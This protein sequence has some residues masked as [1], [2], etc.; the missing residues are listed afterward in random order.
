MQ[1]FHRHALLN[2][3]QKMGL[4]PGVLLDDSVENR[5]NRLRWILY[6]Q[7]K[8]IINDPSIMAADWQIPTLKSSEVGWLHVYGK[9]NRQLLSCLREQ[10]KV[11][12]LTLEDIQSGSQRP[13]IDEYED[14]L[15][16]VL[17]LIN[18]E[19]DDVGIE[20][21]SLFLFQN[22]VISFHEGSADFSQV[23][24][25]RLQHAESH[26]RLGG[27]DFLCYSIMDLLVDH[28]F[29]VLESFGE[30][31]DMIESQLVLNPQPEDMQRIQAVKRV[32]LSLR[33]QIWPTREV[34]NHLQRNI[35]E[36]ALFSISLKPY[37]SDLYDHTIQVMDILEVFRDLATGLMDIYISSVSNRLNDIMRV[38]TVI[39]V[40]FAPMTF[41]A[42]VYGMNFINND[43]SPWA[44]PEI[45]WY[46][47]YPYALGLMFLS[48]VSML[49]YFKKKKWIFS[50]K[51]MHG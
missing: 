44:M 13:K 29:P 25:Q 27:A 34:I 22:L 3:A 28:I 23:I 20:Q 32:M 40:L 19:K 51:K 47:G 50:G 37:L 6:D 8:V 26:L 48:A 41:I 12:P 17:N 46:F 35:N 21:V 9:P 38:L 24:V 16:I 5:E 31:L 33:R 2:H 18:W 10:K 45:H 7:D 1:L 39:T 49:F 15:F 14:Y 36:T 30:F 42:G 4:P 11:H 43:K